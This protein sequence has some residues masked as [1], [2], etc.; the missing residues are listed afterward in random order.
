[1]VVCAAVPFFRF[2][3]FLLLILLA[4]CAPSATPTP[5]LAPTDTPLP[6]TDVPTETPAPTLT[7]SVEVESTSDAESADSTPAAGSAGTVTATLSVT[8]ARVRKAPSVTGETLVE[9]S[10]GDEVVVLGET[11]NQGYVY[12]RTAD[13]IEGWVAKQS[14]AFSDRFA[15]LPVLTPAP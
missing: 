4:A 5:T 2:M 7:P 1:M 13:G 10:Q 14:F 12:V 6:P 3:L 9:I 15:D 8:S 11:A